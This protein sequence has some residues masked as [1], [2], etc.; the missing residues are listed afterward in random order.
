[1]LKKI[2]NNL[3]LKLISALFAVVLWLVVVNIDNPVTTRPFYHIKVDVINKNVITDNG[4]EYKVLDDTDY[5]DITVEGKRSVVD[6]LKNE[7]FTAVA[8]MKN[9]AMDEQLVPIQVSCLQSN[10]DIKIRQNIYNMSVSIEDVITKQ[11]A[12]NTK[13]TGDT[14]EGYA[15]GGVT[16][17][18]NKLKVIGPE[19][20]VNKIK[21]VVVVVDISGL[22][23]SIQKSVTPELY[24]ADGNMIDTSQ[25]VSF[26][27]NEVLVGVEILKTKAL[28]LELNIEGD[29]AEGYRYTGMEFEPKTINIKGT[30]EA[31]QNAASIAVP[32][33]E[34]SVAGASGNIEKV[35]DIS[36]YLP[37]GV[38]LV[39]EDESKVAVTLLIEK[40]I[41]KKFKI[42]LKNIKIQNLASGLD[43]EY[44]SN[45]S[46]EIEIQGLKK[47][48][49]SLKVDSLKSEIDL[50]NMNVGTKDVNIQVTVPD[51]FSVIGNLT[52]TVELKEKKTTEDNIENN[53]NKEEK[54]KAD[55]KKPDSSDD[56]ANNSADNK[57]S[58]SE[59][60]EGDAGNNNNDNLNTDTNNNE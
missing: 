51:G 35:V 59:E 10:R 58:G 23:T 14:G 5:V 8:N 16:L 25:L 9:I 48:L 52:I 50:N 15:L 39:D 42:P 53:T 45:K 49:D 27:S 12:I 3:G 18:Q 34:L 41:T 24:D 1:M 31:L 7:D 46:V 20:I 17:S 47:D 11:F 29:V 55:N 26:D 28:P 60:Q 13:T 21:K 6:N 19:S 33:A 54:D 32:S 43:M 30:S 57:E 56:S 2:T 40:L 36:Q 22:D 44:T 38:Q 37:E 4:K